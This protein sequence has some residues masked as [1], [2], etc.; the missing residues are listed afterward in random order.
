MPGSTALVSVVAYGLSGFA[1]AC[2]VLLAAIGVDRAQLEV[3][4]Q[5]AVDAEAVLVGVRPAEVRIDRR[6][7]RAVADDVDDHR[8]AGLLAELELQVAVDVVPRVGSLS[9]WRSG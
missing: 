8:R 4:H 1:D 6:Q 2:S 5:L 9:S 7:D 3:G